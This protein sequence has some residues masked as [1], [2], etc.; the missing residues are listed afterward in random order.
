VPADGQAVFDLIA[1]DRRRALEELVRAEGEGWLLPRFAPPSWETIVRTMWNVTDDDDVRW[2][3]ARLGPTPIGYF[4]DPVRRT[5]PSARSW[6]VPTF[7][8]GSSRIP[9]SISTRRWHSTRRFGDTGNWRHLI[10]RW[11]PCRTHWRLFCSN[12]LRNI[13]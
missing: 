5:N 4:G 1:P 8:A 12:W 10:T 11:S 9:D 13:S 6:R 3:L 2:M 7:A